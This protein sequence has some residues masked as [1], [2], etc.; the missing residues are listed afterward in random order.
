MVQSPP[1]ILR[2]IARGVKALHLFHHRVPDVGVNLLH[3]RQVFHVACPG[4][5]VGLQ[6][7]LLFQR[8]LRQALV[9]Y[10]KLIPHT[11]PLNRGGS[12]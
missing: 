2:R 12:R 3:V 5:G 6:A 7:V 4:G 8:P 1:D 10:K 9:F 11:P